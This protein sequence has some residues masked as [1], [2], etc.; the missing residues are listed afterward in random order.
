MSGW[1]FGGWPPPSPSDSGGAVTFAAVRAALLLADQPVGFNNQPLQGVLSVNALALNA[2]NTGKSSSVGSTTMGLSTTLDRISVGLNAAA[3]ADPTAD[4]IVA[5][6]ND[7]MTG[8]TT[9]NDDVAIGHGALAALTTGSRNV[10]LGNDAAPLITTQSDGLFVG[11]G[12]GADSV[13]A[14]HI[15]IGAGAVVV[16]PAADDQM[17]ISNLIH[18]GRHGVSGEL[19]MRFGELGTILT[20]EA[21]YRFVAA[22]GDTAPTFELVSTGVNNA[23]VQVFVGTRDPGAAAIVAPNGALY[24][25]KSAA[26]SGIYINRS[27]GATGTSWSLVTAVP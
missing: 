25:R 24:W 8:I 21:G 15:C 14:R 10:A 11:N 1:Q 4:G 5:I 7:A 2:S 20:Q 16:D 19:R 27:A 12:A 26:A 9:G 18:S 13:G 3:N 6:G 22:A 23:A 17:A